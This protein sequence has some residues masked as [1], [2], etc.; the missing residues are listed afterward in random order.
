MAFPV[1]IVDSTTTNRSSPSGS[2]HRK[3]LAGL[4]T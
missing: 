1:G 3:K 4:K 2:R